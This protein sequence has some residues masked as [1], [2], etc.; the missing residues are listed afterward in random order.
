MWQEHLFPTMYPSLIPSLP[1]VLHETLYCTFLKV[2]I[3]MVKHTGQSFRI[4]LATNLCWLFHPKGLLHSSLLSISYNLYRACR[5]KAC[6]VSTS[7]SN[8]VLSLCLLEFCVAWAC[9]STSLSPIIMKED[10]KRAYIS[11]Y[12]LYCLCPSIN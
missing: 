7:Q 1:K 6:F 5:F 11:C 3:I 12:S 4:I 2:N 10:K 8:F 9:S